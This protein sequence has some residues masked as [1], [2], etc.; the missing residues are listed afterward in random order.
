MTL[1][2]SL[3]LGALIG[4]FLGALGGGG[5][6]LTVP[7]LVYLLGEP[8][9]AAT[10]ESLVIVGLTALVAAV[11]HALAR[12]VRWA[13][14]LVF[15]VLGTGASY[16]GT[17]ANRA[18]NPNALLLGFA[19]L[20]MV[21]AL[22]MLARQRRQPAARTPAPVLAV[23]LVATPSAGG[24]DAAGTV[25]TIVPTRAP[26]GSGPAARQLPTGRAPIPRLVAAGLAVGFLTG[27]FGVGGGFIIVPALVMV[28]GMPMPAAVGTS[29]VVIALDSAA[30]LAARAGAAT[31]H[32][33]V[34]VPF[35]IAAVASSAFG[36]QVADRLHPRLLTS[37]FATLLFAVAAY[38]TI[39]SGSALVG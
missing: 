20:I 21:A 5:S 26:A 3:A 23:P 35:T 24:L 36:K 17:A 7:A 27:F 18:A 16:A 37:A 33:T 10:T 22:A 19:A 32:W 11:A 34:I 30:A 2:T 28:L 29:L 25:T 14:G 8:V 1:P 13:A 4:L 31:F 9:R 38:T 15:G 39:T 12:R 6:I